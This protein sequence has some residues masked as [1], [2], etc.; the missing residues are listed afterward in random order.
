MS[1]KRSPS[2]ANVEWWCAIAKAEQPKNYGGPA[3]REWLRDRQNARDKLAEHCLDWDGRLTDWGR[4]N[5]YK[6]P[7]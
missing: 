3:L 1:Q 2:K 6:E 5:G 7:K 4:A